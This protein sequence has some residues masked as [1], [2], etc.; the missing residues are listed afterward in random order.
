MNLT[1]KQ[2][3]KALRQSWAADTAFDASDWSEANPARG[4]CVV[5]ALVVQ[6]YFGGDLQRYKVQGDVEET[7]YVNLLFEGV[8]FD[9]TASQY[10]GK[11][12]QLT[13]VPVNLK[14]FASAREKCLAG[15]DT[16]ERYERLRRRVET[17]LEKLA[18]R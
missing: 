11:N 4:Q 9:T 8:I 3:A 2:L 13:P 14:G 10:D 17:L 16:R 1:P 15:G 12:V 18:E 5:S 6:D 7:H